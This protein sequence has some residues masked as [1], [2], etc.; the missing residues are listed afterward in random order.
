VGLVEVLFPGP[1]AIGESKQF[2]PSERRV[3]ALKLIN[4]MPIPRKWDFG[5]VEYLSGNELNQPLTT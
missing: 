5:R 1:I 4:A 3:A 2:G